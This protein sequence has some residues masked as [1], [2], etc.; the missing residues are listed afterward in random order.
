VTGR[1]F[2]DNQEVEAADFAVDPDN[3]DRLWDLAVT[4]LR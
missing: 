2:E 1:Y 3:A 4:A